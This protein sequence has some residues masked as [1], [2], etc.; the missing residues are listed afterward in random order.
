L[1]GRRYELRACCVMPNHVHVVVEP[2]EG[3]T[4]TKILHS[5]KSFT[6][7]Q[8][9]RIL[10]RSGSFWQTEYFDHLIR[11]EQ[12]MERAIEYVWKNPDEAGMK[13]WPWRWRVDGDE[14][15]EAL[16]FRLEQL[17]HGRDAR[18]TEDA[19]ADP[20]IAAFRYIRSRLG[21]ETGKTLQL[22]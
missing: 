18:A 6:A 10:E 7:H 14:T 4:L 17:G 1:H 3:A 12:D 8:A 2:L 16:K 20:Q 21:I 11:D 15:L 19:D 5:W 13:N 9:N 22:G